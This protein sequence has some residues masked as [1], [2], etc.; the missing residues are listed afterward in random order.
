MGFDAA[1]KTIVDD[2][3]LYFRDPQQDLDLGRWSFV[4]LL[5]HWQTEHAK[6]IFVP[7]IATD[8]KPREY[9]YGTKIHVV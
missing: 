7:C 6:A 9:S 5:I 3:Y 4:K 1:T 8:T 2:G